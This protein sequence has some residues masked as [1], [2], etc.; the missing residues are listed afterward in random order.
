MCFLPEEACR[1]WKNLLLHPENFGA[2][3]ELYQGGK[4]L[5]LPSGSC[6]VKCKPLGAVQGVARSIRRSLRIVYLKP[7]VSCRDSM[8]LPLVRVWVA[9]LNSHLRQVS[10]SNSLAPTA[11]LAHFRESL[12]QPA[13]S[14]SPPK[15]SVLQTS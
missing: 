13:D 15:P 7:V 5:L 2:G 11:V 10:Q 8:L 1:K 4:E 14:R 12:Q 9:I 3:I 6:N